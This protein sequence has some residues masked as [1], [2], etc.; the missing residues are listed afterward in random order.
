MLLPNRHESSNEYRY[1]FGGYEKDDEVSGEGNSYTS[2]YRQYDPRIGR[3]KSVDP[4]A[5]K[6]AWSSP[7]VFANNNPIY[8]TDVY[9]GEPEDAGDREKRLN[10][11]FRT[12]R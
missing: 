6:F 2:F 12:K 1:G 5:V 11:V 3:F 8:F 7:Y 10:V 9:G 4:A